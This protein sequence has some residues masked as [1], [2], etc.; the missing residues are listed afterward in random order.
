MELVSF[1]GF[2][3]NSWESPERTKWKLWGV[4][5][6]YLVSSVPKVETTMTIRFCGSRYIHTC[7]Q[8]TDR[9]SW[10]LVGAKSMP[11]SSSRLLSSTFSRTLPVGTLARMEIPTQRC[12]C[13]QRALV[14]TYPQ[15]VGEIEWV[16]SEGQHQSPHYPPST[17]RSDWAWLISTAYITRYGP[18]SIYTCI[19]WHIRF[20]DTPHTPLLM[21]V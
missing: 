7:S 18:S 4:S 14:R 12:K 9:H 16:T 1:S 11:F 13:G 19:D 3:L 5:A 6:K 10:R 20:A 17:P 8:G 21:V 15:T 2:R